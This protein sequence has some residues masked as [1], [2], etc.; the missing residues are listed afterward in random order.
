[1]LRTVFV[2]IYHMFP[3]FRLSE[4][5][6][7]GRIVPFI[8]WFEKA[9]RNFFMPYGLNVFDKELLKLQP[10]DGSYLALFGAWITWFDFN[11]SIYQANCTTWE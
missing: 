7:I 11:I 8:W 10:L 6:I 1:M 2:S 5:S 9:K 4:Y 3:Y